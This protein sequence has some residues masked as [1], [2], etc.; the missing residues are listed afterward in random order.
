[1]SAALRL[2]ADDLERTA[3]FLRAL[4]AA[5]EEFGIELAP[6]GRAEIKVADT[7]VS[8][9]WDNDQYVLDDQ[10]GA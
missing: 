7:V 6:Y 2:D 9:V 5:T 3:K 1:M 10:V 4:T 8:I